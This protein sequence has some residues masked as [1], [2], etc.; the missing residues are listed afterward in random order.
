MPGWSR[1]NDEKTSNEPIVRPDWETRLTS[2]QNDL[3][4]P[5][6]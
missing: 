4:G 3:A 6:R 1:R 2:G 5:P